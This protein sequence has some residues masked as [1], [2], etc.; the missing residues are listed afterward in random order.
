MKAAAK[1]EAVKELQKSFEV[2]LRRACG[3]MAL[4]TSSAYYEGG[5]VR[6][7][8]P[9]RAALREG[10][11]RRRRWGYRMLTDMLRCQGFEDN[12]KRIYR[13]YREEGLQVPMR[14][15]RK[16]GRWRGEKPEL[17]LAPTNAGAWTS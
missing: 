13:I 16:K 1:R 7:D 12:H 17:P 9:L 10:T 8:G 14:K 15:R 4:S 2:S 3:L 11:S 6:D 5:S